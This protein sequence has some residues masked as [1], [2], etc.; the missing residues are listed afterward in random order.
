MWTSVCGGLLTSTQSGAVINLKAWKWFM[1]LCLVFCLNIS[2]VS[3]IKSLVNTN[4]MF[5]HKV[6]LKYICPIWKILLFFLHLTKD[7]FE[8]VPNENWVFWPSY[9]IVIFKWWCQTLVRAKNT[10]L[11]S[12][13]KEFFF[14]KQVAKWN[15]NWKLSGGKAVGRQR[16]ESFTA[17]LVINFGWLW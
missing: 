11:I 17:T 9:F 10:K 8:Q 7:G 16:C 14:L 3:K 13:H 6:H 12:S 2:Q 5:F 4:L 15:K 1:P